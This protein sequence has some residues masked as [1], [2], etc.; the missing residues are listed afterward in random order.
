MRGLERSK[1]LALEAAVQDVENLRS[2]QEGLSKDELS[3]IER[4]Q[5]VL[6]DTI[7][8]RWSGCVLGLDKSK[9]FQ[10]AYRHEETVAK[11]LEASSKLTQVCMLL[12]T[13]TFM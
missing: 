11:Q 13:S 12:N 9:A 5:K 7:V 4:V 2:L 1:N 3:K 8:W 6:Q 10:A